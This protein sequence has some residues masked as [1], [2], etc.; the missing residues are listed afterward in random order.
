EQLPAPTQDDAADG[1]AALVQDD[2]LVR[3][4]PA[5]AE[6]GAPADRGDGLVPLPGDLV[7]VT[8]LAQFGLDGL[9]R[10]RCR[11]TVFPDEN[12]HQIA[13]RRAERPSSPA[14]A[15][16]GAVVAESLH[17]AAVRCSVWF[18]GLTCRPLARP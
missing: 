13:L 2:S 12:G 3:D 15:A 5:G 9:P 1:A 10:G 7:G 18:G 6:H 16:R 4:L 11:R 14:A 8:E 17:A